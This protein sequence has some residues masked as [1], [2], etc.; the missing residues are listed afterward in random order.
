MSLKNIFLQDAA[1]VYS[2]EVNASTIIF[3][4]DTF[5]IQNTEL[6]IHP[7]RLNV[8]KIF[9]KNSFLKILAVGQEKSPDNHPST[10]IYLPS[11]EL[12]TGMVFDITSVIFEDNKISYHKNFE[13]RTDQFNPSHVDLEE[14]NMNLS[15]IL[16]HEDTIS[17]DLQYLS[18]LLPG[19]ILESSAN[20]QL[21]RHLVDLS[22]LNVRANNSQFSANI[23]GSYPSASA[24]ENDTSLLQVSV[25]T[26]FKPGDLSYFTRNILPTN[27]DQW[28]NISVDLDGNFRMETT[29][30]KELKVKRNDSHFEA[31]GVVY[32][33]L[34]REKLRWQN[35]KVNGFFGPDIGSAIA[36]IIGRIKFPKS[37]QFELKT[38]GHTG[39][40]NF[41]AIVHTPQGNLSSKGFLGLSKRRTEIHL[42]TKG[43]KVDIGE[44]FGLPWLGQVSL[45][46]D[47]KG[48]MSQGTNLEIIG[49]IDEIEILDQPVRDIAFRTN[50]TNF[51]AISLLSIEDPE[52]QSKIASEIFFLKPLTAATAIHFTQF[53]LGSILRMDSTLLL[54]GE[55]H[56]NTTIGENVSQNVISGK[57]IQLAD[58]SREYL[59]DTLSLASNSSS[60]YT[61]VT[62]FDDYTEG[63]LTANFDVSALPTVANTIGR[64]LLRRG[65]GANFRGSRLLH[66]NIHMREIKPLQ[67]F[68][69]E[70]EDLVSLDVSATYDEQRQVAGI[71]ASGADFKGYGISTD[72]FRIKL[73]TN[74]DSAS[75]EVYGKNLLYNSIH[76]G[77]LS[78]DANTVGDTTIATLSLQEDSASI[79]NLTSWVIASDSGALV[80]PLRL[81][82]LENEYTVDR[83]NP[84]YISD[85][86]IEVDDFMITRELMQIRLDGN[87]R[88]IDANLKNLDL[89]MLNKFLSPDSAII[90]SGSLDANLS[91]VIDSINLT[92]NIDSLCIFGSTPM[93]FTAKVASNKTNLPFEFL[94]NN[95]SDKINIEG[96]YNFDSK[97]VGA[98]I[99]IDIN[100]LQ[101]FKFLTSGFLADLNGKFNG[102][103]QATG[104]LQNPRLN[105][106][107]RFS[108][109]SFT[110]INPNFTINVDDGNVELNNSTLLLKNFTIY[111][112][113]N[114][115]LTINGH[116]GT[117]DYQSLDYG[118]HLNTEEFTLLNNPD[119]AS[120]RLTGSLVIASEIDINGDNKGSNVKANI[121]IKDTTA[122]TYTERNDDLKTNDS[123]GIIEFIDPF[124]LADTISSARSANFYDSL[125]A[126]LP[127][128]KLNS[129]VNIEEDAQLRYIIDALSGDYI[130]ASGSGAL[131]LEYD[132]TGNVRLSGN[133]TI[134]EGL[135]RVSFYDL[136][137]KNFR[138]LPESTINWN[139]SPEDGDLK[140]KAVYTIKTSSIGLIGNE[141]SENEQSIY[142]RA[143]P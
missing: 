74:G 65:N 83:S 19:L 107:V 21:N 121:T 20:I 58:D 3:N 46:I 80:Y 140:I 8:Q 28:E 7:D 88:A 101:T 92:A 15:R 22:E 94:L 125:I 85:N 129:L 93:E 138:L 57:N 133:Y 84:I 95:K 78:F 130:Q 41:D 71:T 5:A 31:S 97:E 142:K 63:N 61:I 79:F 112:T 116:I 53:N 29:E 62:Y 126:S 104:H 26:R 123:E 55:F 64:D 103:M 45:T 114:N 120:S 10:T 59:L 127:E 119:T 1:V 131:D 128:F 96:Q 82:G 13:T 141:I 44:L 91:Y 18:F 40:I 39:R 98:S 108:K 54:S 68:G 49:K 124:Q 25:T 89:T 111:D 34:D 24:D 113:D 99:L 27:L 110:G 9:L 109:A 106:S 51:K 77:N 42:N 87:L 37:L 66:G 2:S 105:G 73:A 12:G 17:G 16:I 132:R 76:L 52:Y 56:A 43:E 35:L 36:P 47:A 139:G 135:Y 6:S 81:Q 69:I 134:K 38:S 32:N 115:A 143:L 122:L 100:D 90:N 14:I 72:T 70:I 30:I 33:I 86:N 23:N 50:L 102:T 60:D 118:L 4:A 48:A 137:K 117:S 75:A 67:L 11:L 136:V